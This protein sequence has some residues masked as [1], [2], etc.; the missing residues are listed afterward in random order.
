M[1]ARNPK[2]PPR[3]PIEIKVYEM[4]GVHVMDCSECGVFDTATSEKEATPQCTLHLMEVHAAPYES[5]TREQ[6]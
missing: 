3:H 6:S 2:P 1:S 5:I 4:D